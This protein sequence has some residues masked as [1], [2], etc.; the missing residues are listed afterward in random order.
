MTINNILYYI[1]NIDLQV[2]IASFSI[3]PYKALIFMIG[4]SLLYIGLYRQKNE[5]SEWEKELHEV[6]QEKLGHKIFR[7]SLYLAWLLMIFYIWR[8]YELPDSHLL[9]FDL[10]KK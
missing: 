4:V 9:K 3:L 1:V 2:L 10:I 8:K 6:S 5:W 7:L